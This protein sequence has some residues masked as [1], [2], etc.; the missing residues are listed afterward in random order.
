MSATPWRGTLVFAGGLAAVAVTAAARFAGASPDVAGTAAGTTSDGTT[1]G[2]ATSEPAATGAADGSSGGSAATAPSA[3][4]SSA[5]SSAADPAAAATATPTADPA[6]SA[7]SVTIVGSTVQT[8]FGPLQLQVTFDGSDITD[9][10][11]LQYPSW[12]GESVQINGYAIPI[13]NQEAVAANSATIDAVSGA[14]IT[15][16]AYRQSLQA[17]IDQRG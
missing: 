5:S 10:Q 8:R 4:D 9:V 12:H 6:A 15:S 7:G 14:T 2:T 1:N 11:A 17:A 3:G 13:L 16:Q